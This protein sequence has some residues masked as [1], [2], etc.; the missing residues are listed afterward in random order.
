MERKTQNDLN[1]SGC[2]SEGERT[3]LSSPAKRAQVSSEIN[4]ARC[5]SIPGSAGEGW[6][7]TNSH[8]TDLTLNVLHD[9]ILKK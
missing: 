8:P 7:T 4:C 2:A 1:D 6:R 3:T 5:A 9:A